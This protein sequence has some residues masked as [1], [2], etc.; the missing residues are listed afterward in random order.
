MKCFI[1]C[2]F[3][4]YEKWP[5]CENN[6]SALLAFGQFRQIRMDQRN[7]WSATALQPGLCPVPPRRRREHNEYGLAAHKA[8]LRRALRQSP[9]N[10]DI[11]LVFEFPPPIASERRC[12]APGGYGGSL[13]PLFREK[14]GRVECGTQPHSCQFTAV[15]SLNSQST[16]SEIDP[17]PVK[18]ISQTNWPESDAGEDQSADYF[19]LLYGQAAT[20]RAVR[21]DPTTRRRVWGAGN[22]CEQARAGAAASL[23]HAITTW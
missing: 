10:A 6:T 16:F 2:A 7:S 5:K 18:Q 11:A 21:V 20:W 23:I 1:D 17:L 13:T 9:T 8:A 4:R 12:L 22:G 19:E 14:R 15:A 3:A